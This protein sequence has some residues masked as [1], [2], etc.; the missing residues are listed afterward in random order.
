M[1][2]RR[3]LLGTWSWRRPFYSLAFI[4]LAL[5]MFGCF[6]VD[7]LVFQPPPSIKR[8]GAPGFLQLPTPAGE[9]VAAIHLPPKPGR[10]TLLYSHGNAEDLGGVMPLLEPWHEQGFG[11][12]AYD[13]PGYGQSTGKPTEASCERSIEAAWNHLTGPLGVASSSIILVG[14]SV[15]SGPAV[16]LCTRQQPA[17][18]VL[19]SPI[20]SVYRVRLPAPIFPGDRFPNLERMPDVSCPLLVV[21]G[22]SDR[23][24]P[25]K[26]GRRLHQAHPGPDK[27][28]LLIPG[29]GHNNL[30]RLAGDEIEQAIL[31]F[32]ERC[33]D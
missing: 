14:R 8:P 16:W 20:M 19:I 11:I 25:A 6:C 17:G 18:L 26:H 24:V 21:H 3:L 5:S 1:K 4:Y 9:S 7:N 27:N 32:A 13:Y 31:G 22:D 23:V 28:I 29:A 2:W 33:S 15:G 12:L 10:P 30:F